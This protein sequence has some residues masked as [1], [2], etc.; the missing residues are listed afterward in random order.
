M[1]RLMLLV[2]LLASYF[3]S[4]AQK[5]FQIKGVV[6]DTAAGLKLYNT[7]IS[8]L[9]AKDSTLYRFTRASEQGAFSFQQL[10][11]GKYQL[12]F[13]YP[14]YVDYI[15][16]IELSAENPIVDLKSINLFS[17][18]RML[19]EVLIKGQVA[20]IK[21]KGDTTEYN[22][23]S[24]SI[25]PNDKVEDLLKK[26]PDM[27]IDKDGKITAQGKKVTKVLV[28]GEEFFGD[29][30]TLATRNLR[31]DM[32]DKVQ[33][34]DK[35]SEQAAF[36]GVDDGQKETTLNIKL[37]ED[38]KNGYFGKVTGGAAPEGFYEGQ[39]MFNR[40]KAKQKFS[41]YGTASNN[42]KTGLSWEDSNKLG[43]GG[44]NFEI[45]DGGLM[46]FS[47]GDMDGGSQ[48]W[49][50]GIPKAL[51]GGLHYDTKWNGDKHSINTNYKA[52]NLAID[53][54]KNILNQNSLPTGIINSN[55]DE[56]TNQNT[57]RQKLDAIY[58]VKLDTTS[59]L[60]ISVDGMR[61]NNDNESSYQSM[62]KRGNNTLLNT[63]NRTNTTEGTNT[64]F[65]LAALYTKKLKKK[66]RNFSVNL[67]Q[68]INETSSDG[69]LY[70]KNDFYN[71]NEVLS[72]QTI[73]DQL[74][75][76]ASDVSTLMGN[77]TYNE[78][79]TQAFTAVFNYGFNRTASTSD[80]RSYNASSPGQYTQLDTEFSN[81]FEATQFTSN[82]GLIFNYNKPKTVINFGTRIS[83]TSIDQLETY[84]AQSF[85]RNFVNWLPEFTYQYKFSTQRSFRVSYRGNTSQPRIEQL[86]P[87]KV[88]TDPLNIPLGN[89]DLTPSYSS[90]M[91]MSYNSYKVLTSESIYIDG[92]LS[93]T[94]NQ[95]VNKTTTDA[96]GKSIRQAI[97]LS[98]HTPL[99][100][101]LYTSYSRKIKAINT[102]V[103]LGINGNGGY[104]F[105]YINGNL[106]K[107]INYS[108]GPSL[109]INRYTEKFN[110]YLNFGPSF[111][112]QS[113][114]VQKNTNNTG[115]GRRAYGNFNYNLSKKFAISSD[116]QY[117]YSPKTGTF[118]NSFEQTLVNAT[119]T[120]KFFKNNDLNIS[121]TVN[122]LF[123]QNLGFSRYASGNIISQTS[124]N[125]IKRYFMLSATW[126]FNKMGGAPKQ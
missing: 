121:L 57:F 46:V 39:G 19:N 59:N 82:S 68:R 3:N 86:Q 95:I 61:V 55:S 17:K 30:P 114:S 45:M 67:T 44:S 120:K 63:T 9:T 18:A 91:N 49:G 96:E 4:S 78:P 33:L 74:K 87:V 104:S 32:V 53:I 34:F 11:P 22:A 115:W 89:P 99:N 103:G 75:V 123:N 31:A 70:A 107:T 43:T 126:E 42:G 24:Y 64:T 100:F 122:D 92:G 111:T 52:G 66:G 65:N 16:P 112:S 124:Y 62:D 83:A 113:A 97:N 10:K 48:Y 8:I 85:S 15:H 35:A 108:F 119:L 58:N 27:Q 80:R 47:G 50:E 71:E 41:A 28:D 77:V 21:I 118:N 36:T 79:I 105:N 20:A 81:K 116:L 72:N 88:N 54:R 51:N 56:T 94:N 1:K 93:F 110:F 69:F 98:D 5:D 2:L 38:K 101:N 117:S 60:R 40:F 29:D 106:N 125:N 73:V 6:A 12:L 26:F 14:N 13:T 84:T 102:Q 109:N 23:S 7:S 25:Q 76:N 37:K 90:R